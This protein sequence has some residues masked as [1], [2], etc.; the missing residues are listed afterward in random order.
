MA[1]L[2]RQAKL[3]AQKWRWYERNGL[4]LHRARIHWHLM[5]REA[6]ARWPLHG[7][8]LEMLDDGRLQIGAGTLLEPGVWITAPAPATPRC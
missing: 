1:D 4:P 2:P 7:D 3:W 5:R 8:V 6:F